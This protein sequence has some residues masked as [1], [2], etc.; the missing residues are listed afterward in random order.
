MKLDKKTYLARII[1]IVVCF[2]IAVLC[3]VRMNQSYDELARYPYVNDDNRDILL[4]YLDSDDINYMINQQIRPEQFMDFIVLDG[5]ELRFA[6]LYSAAKKAQ[7]SDNQ[8][9]INFV[10][11]YRSHFSLKTLPDLLKY[12]S[13]IDLITFYETEWVLNE[14]LK[15]V[16]DLS[17]PFVILNSTQTI[18]K[19]KPEVVSFQNIF[20]QQACLED[21]KAMCEDYKKVLGKELTFER[22]YEDYETILNQYN[23]FKE[24]YPDYADLYMSTAGQNEMQLGYS[25]IISGLSQWLIPYLDSLNSS[26]ETAVEFVNLETLEWLMDNSY[27][28][29]FVMRFKEDKEEQSGKAYNPY[30]FRYVGKKNAKKMFKS[31]LCMEEMEFS[32]L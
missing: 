13:Y 27:R 10:N 30:V 16:S 22:G 25:I 18:Y 32:S 17:D 2:C 31:N 1:L 14:N 29:G 12:Y 8:S 3:Y 11:R 5:F 24:Q 23:G 26:E 21:L 19:Y 15:L 28:Y 9:I 4:K 20:I 7:N 6:L